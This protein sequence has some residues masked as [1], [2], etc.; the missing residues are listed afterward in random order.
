MHPDACIA[1]TE[2]ALL[3]ENCSEDLKTCLVKIKLLLCRKDHVCSKLRPFPVKKI[4]VCKVLEFCCRSF[5]EEE[6][7]SMSTSSV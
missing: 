3:N 1:I 2:V 4:M 7:L 6:G 5:I